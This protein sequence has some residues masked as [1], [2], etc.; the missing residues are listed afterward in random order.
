MDANSTKLGSSPPGTANS[1]SHDA[2]GVLGRR[3]PPEGHA[4]PLNNVIAVSAAVSAI[5]R[6]NITTDIKVCAQGTT[7]SYRVLDMPTEVV[8]AVFPQ[9]P[10]REGM[11]VVRLVLVRVSIAERS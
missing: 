11:T 2:L 3:H 1:L 10:L 4:Q 9:R 5:S 6:S 8:A 7:D